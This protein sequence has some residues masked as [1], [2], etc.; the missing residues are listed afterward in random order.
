MEVQTRR[1]RGIGPGSKQR[2]QDEQ[3]R[4][5][6][7]FCS[8]GQ[9]QTGPTHLRGLTGLV[10][11]DQVGVVRHQGLVSLGHAEERPTA[12]GQQTWAGVA[13]LGP[14]GEDVVEGGQLDQRI[15][16]VRD[17]PA[18][19]VEEERDP[20]AGSGDAAPGVDVGHGIEVPG[21]VDAEDGDALTANLA[22]H[23]AGERLGFERAF[24]VPLVQDRGW[25]DEEPEP[26]GVAGEQAG[27][28]RSRT[29]GAGGQAEGPDGLAQVGVALRQHA[30]RGR[31]SWVSDTHERHPRVVWVRTA[32]AGGLMAPSRPAGIS[33]ISLLATV[34]AR[35]PRLAIALVG[36][37]RGPNRGDR[38]GLRRLVGHVA[39]GG[40]PHST[41][42]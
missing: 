3:V 17:G 14:P 31:P 1:R 19:G 11:E 39:V 27:W 23:V 7:T 4:S 15:D 32:N 10:A 35:L 12:G 5:W 2:R 30:W 38:L 20:V 34:A 42:A 18:P 6:G 37:G 24:P 21:D 33:G 25:P 41:R 16:Q 22:D 9:T 26:E 8:L 28:G 36:V 29:G 40:R 13:V